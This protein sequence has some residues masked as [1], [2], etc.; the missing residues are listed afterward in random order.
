VRIIAAACLLYLVREQRSSDS[1][2]VF[3]HGV[4]AQRYSWSAVNDDDCNG[5]GV[6]HLSA[7]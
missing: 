4:E 5:F 7:D 1:R 6:W 3:V 2:V